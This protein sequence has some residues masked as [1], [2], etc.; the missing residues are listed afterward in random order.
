MEA[1]KKQSKKKILWMIPYF[2]YPPITGGNVR[3]F[4]LI[5]YLSEYFDI[6]LLSF[7]DK[8]TGNKDV[9]FLEQF[10]Q[11]VIV[12]ERKLYHGELP[13]IFQEYDTP[14]MYKELEKVLKDKF[15]FVQ[16][17]FLV[18]AYYVKLIK[19]LAKTP[20][21]FTEHDVSSFYFD[22][23]FHNRH[24]PEKERFV[25]WVRMHKIIKQ[26]YPLFDLILTVSQNDAEILKKFFPKLNIHPAPTGTDCQYYKFK[27]KRLNNDLIYVGHYKHFPNVDAVQY[28]IDEIFPYVKQQFNLKFY[29]VGSSAED[30]FA[31]L[32]NDKIVVIGTVPDIRDYLYNTGIFVAPIKLGIGIRGKLLEAMASGLPVISTSIG[33]K[34]INAEDKKHLLIADTPEEFAKQIRRLMQDSNLRGKLI[35]NARKFVEEKFNWPVL[36]KNMI[37]IYEGIE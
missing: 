2:P 7:I 10:C 15:D 33:A 18:M 16:I 17:D 12:V 31:K 25:E 29:I 24:L 37:Q 1:L 6:T 27:E 14:E 35:S 32:N 11:K 4:N 13:L 34:G 21:I 19:N 23:C 28:F 26:I 20:V 22:K 8:R 36:V 5:K 30:V 9:E 3:V